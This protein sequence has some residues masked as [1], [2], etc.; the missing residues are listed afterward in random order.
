MVKYY[1]TKEYLENPIGNIKRTKIFS[2]NIDFTTKPLFS[3][4]PTK[5][6]KDKAKAYVRKFTSTI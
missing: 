4:T 5:A 3:N 6:E 1:R 2:F